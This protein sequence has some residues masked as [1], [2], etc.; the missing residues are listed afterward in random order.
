MQL[1]RIGIC[2]L[3]MGATGALLA[4]SAAP[5]ARARAIL[6]FDS[7]WRFLKA[8]TPGA[9]APAF[10]DSQWRTVAVPHDWRIEGPFEQ[11]A[12]PGGAGAFL[13]AGVGWYR[14]HFTL[15]DYGAQARVFI[16]FDGVMANSDVWIN[17]FHLGKRP[18]GYVTFRYELTGHVNTGS[19]PNVLAV[20]ADDSAQPASRW[21][22]GGGIYRHVRLIVMAPVH[23]A[24]W[25]VIVTTPSVTAGSATVSIQSKLV[26]QGSVAAACDRPHH[27]HRARWAACAERG[28]CHA[29]RRP[30]PAREREAAGCHPESR[31]GGTS[32]ARISTRPR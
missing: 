25:G 14:K 28:R 31:S 4:Q 12:P 7:D 6:P 27:H 19:Q 15:A 3:L 29:D 23:I 26:N 21:Y 5:S 32:T 2:F 22:S 10:D 9:E 8:D 20:R 24:Q 13:P 11:D 30:G 1:A 16:E 18:Y 17:G